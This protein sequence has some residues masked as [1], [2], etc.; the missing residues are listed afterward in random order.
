MATKQAKLKSTINRILVAGTTA[1]LT[2]NDFDLYVDGIISTAIRGGEIFSGVSGTAPIF[3]TATTTAITLYVSKHTR[4]TSIADDESSLHWNTA[5]DDLGN[6]LQL[7][8]SGTLTHPTEGAFS[9]AENLYYCPAVYP[10][11]LGVSRM[12]AVLKNASIGFNGVFSNAQ[13]NENS[14]IK[15]DKLTPYGVVEII[16]Y[17][18]RY[19]PVI[20]KYLYEAYHIDEGGTSV[21]FDVEYIANSVNS[22]SG[23]SNV[24]LTATRQQDSAVSVFQIST[25]SLKAEGTISCTLQAG[26]YTVV[27]SFVLNGV[28]YTLSTTGVTVYAAVA[29]ITSLIVN[30]YSAMTGS[31]S[32][33]ATATEGKNYSIYCTTYWEDPF[34]YPITTYELRSF[35]ADWTMQA[36][37]NSKTVTIPQTMPSEI[38]GDNSYMIRSVYVELRTTAGTVVKSA[39][40]EL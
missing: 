32:L 27:A 5:E 39:M 23:I 19:A 14:I 7:R 37:S 4:S 15:P 26:N 12:A 25:P 31:M 2:A 3:A 38:A 33:T 40:Y 34:A 29:N 8:L 24:K 35:V 28:T 11:N 22:S 18:P 30:S 1:N 16:G 9:I 36:G 6:V 20:L 10:P 17:S 13:L 21:A